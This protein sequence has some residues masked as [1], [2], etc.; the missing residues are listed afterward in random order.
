MEHNNKEK[1]QQERKKSNGRKK[2][3]VTYPD[4]GELAPDL[5][6]PDPTTLIPWDSLTAGKLII[7]SIL[8]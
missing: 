1:K 8:M 6:V 7:C 3:T 2:N 5:V 4:D